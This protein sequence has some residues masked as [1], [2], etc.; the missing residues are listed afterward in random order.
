MRPALIIIVCLS[1][2]RMH[3]QPL[4]TRMSEKQTG[5]SFL[6]KIE[7]D[8]SL[9]VMRYEYL[10]NG[11]GVGIADLNND[12]L[13][14]IFFSSNTGS[15]KLYLNKGNFRFEDVTRLAHVGGNGTWCTG[16]SM[17]DV[18][19]DGLMDI[20]VCHSGKY[21]DPI[22]LCNELYICQGIKEGIPVYKEMAKEYGLDAPG[23]QSTQAVFFDY[24]KDGDLDL[25]LLNHPTTPITLISIPARPVRRRIC[26]S[27]TAC[28]A[29]TGTPPA[30]FNLQT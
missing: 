29:R 10:Y 19:G 11:G 17:A 20:Y 21:D 2:V 27:E 18:N 5:I 12:G 28:S 8:D 30:I 16:V 1:A 26:T 15:C 24:D 9:N 13:D 6:N 3:A 23:T 22:K 14:D 25:F 7:E 4:F